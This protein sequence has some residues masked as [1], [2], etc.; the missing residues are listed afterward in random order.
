MLKPSRH[1]FCVTLYYTLFYAFIHYS[2]QSFI[3]EVKHGPSVNEMKVGL[4]QQKLGLCD[5]RQVT[6]VSVIREMQKF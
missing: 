6:P 2:V 3:T 5:T 1:V 4:Q